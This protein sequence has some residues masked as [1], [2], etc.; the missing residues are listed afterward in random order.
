MAEEVGVRHRARGRG[1]E[2][3]GDGCQRR[4]DAEEAALGSG[5]VVVASRRR[6]VGRAYRRL[7]W[8]FPLRLLEEAEVGVVGECRSGVVREV[9]DRGVGVGQ[10]ITEPEAALG[11]QGK[12]RWHGG[13]PSGVGEVRDRDCVV[14]EEAL[15][16]RTIF[17]RGREDGC[18]H[19]YRRV[20]FKDVFRRAGHGAA[21]GGGGDDISQLVGERASR[22]QEGSA[23]GH[24]AGARGRSRSFHG[25][26]RLSGRWSRSRG[27]GRCG[28]LGRRRRGTV[29]GRAWLRSFAAV[30]AP[31]E[32]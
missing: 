30:R 29:E 3:S 13:A 23:G 14:V 8:A 32:L 31:A 12:P 18:A 15:L 21:C 24:G 20:C 26:R 17:T 7:G 27:L 2:V 16:R 28:G 19:R 5:L 10:G 11:L 22:W 25:A 4:E 9:R 6:G 1:V